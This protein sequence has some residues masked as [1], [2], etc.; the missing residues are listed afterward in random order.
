MVLA[1]GVPPFIANRTP[2]RLIHAGVL[3]LLTIVWGVVII[4]NRLVR[5]K[6]LQQR[7]WSLIEV[8]LQRRAHL[9]PQP[10]EVANGYAQHE[11]SLQEAVTRARSDGPAAWLVLA[12]SY[13]QLNA[14]T[15]F[16][17]VAAELTDTENRIAAAREYFN[18]AVTTLR[19]RTSS[20]PG[21]LLV[22]LARSGRFGAMDHIAAGGE[23]RVA[24][25][26]RRLLG[27]T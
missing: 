1:F 20:F 24:P 2:L 14:D 10:A 18:D 27:A 19:D 17:K 15:V 22:A 21:L 23:E 4:H 13:P 8:Q 16:A 12:E 6:H 9:I 26:L 5:I 11:A 7:A 3:V 25:D